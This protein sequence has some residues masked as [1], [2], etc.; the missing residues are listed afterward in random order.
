MENPMSWFEADSYC[1]SLGA[2]LAEIDSEEENAVIVEEINRGGY[3]DREMY[4]WIGLTDKDKERTWKLASNGSGAVFLNWDD[5]TKEPN[6]N[7]NE[8]CAHIRAG[9]CSEWDHSGW[10]DLDCDKTMVAITCSNVGTEVQF[11]MNA[12]CEFESLES[13]RKD[14]ETET[15]ANLEKVVFIKA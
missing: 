3:K 11:S 9:G 4:F 6:N 13:N 5:K 12:L 1:K 8:D 10:A 15:G 14:A 7:G 2:K